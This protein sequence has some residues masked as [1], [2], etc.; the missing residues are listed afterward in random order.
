[1]FGSPMDKKK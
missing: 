1:M